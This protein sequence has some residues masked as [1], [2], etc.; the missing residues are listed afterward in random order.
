MLSTDSSAA[1]GMASRR[2]AGAVRHIHVQTLW[3]QDAITAKRLEIR[4][5]KGELNKGDLGTKLHTAEK[6][7]AL[8]ALLGLKRFLGRSAAQV[9][10]NA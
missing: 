8:L 2:G 4:K 7:W 6:T 5:Q 3:L 10:V 1:K 9:D